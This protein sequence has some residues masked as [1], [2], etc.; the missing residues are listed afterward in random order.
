MSREKF[1][2]GPGTGDAGELPQRG[3]GWS[4]ARQKQ[5]GDAA[6][7]AARRERIAVRAYY[8]AERRGFQGDGQ[9]EDWLSAERDIDDPSRAGGV[10]QEASRQRDGLAESGLKPQRDNAGGER[11]GSLVED[12]KQDLKNTE[13]S[14][15]VRH[16]TADN[17][18]GTLI[19]PKKARAIR[20]AKSGM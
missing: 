14:A 13:Y 4:A 19:P 17:G 18:A 9:L 15:E 11:V 3:P 12:I 6:D 10:Q 8:N 20:K 1:G 5:E 2:P 7:W 16:S